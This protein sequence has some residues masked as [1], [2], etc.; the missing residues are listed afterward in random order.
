LNNPDK[1]NVL[2]IDGSA[3][4]FLHANKP[5]YED[6]IKEHV[7]RLLEMY[8]TDS[9][10][11]FLEKSKS[12]FRNCVASTHIYKG[13]REAN[14]DKTNDYLPYLSEVFDACYKVFNPIIYYGIEND[15]ALSLTAR[16]Y[17]DSDDYNPIIVGDDSD[18]LSIEGTHYRMRRNEEMSVSYPGTIMLVD[19][20][21]QKQLK[22]TGL[23]STYSKVLKGAA[24]EN[25]KGIPGYG[26]KKV[27]SLLKDINNEADMRKLCF[28]LFVKEFGYRH[29][30]HRLNEGFR[31]C[32]LLKYNKYFTLPPIQIFNKQT[33]ETM[34]KKWK[35]IT[36]P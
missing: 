24:K 3:F 23:Y 28:D 12:N 19:K 2:L 16:A 15:D 27:Y 22:A 17:N 7:G 21:K 8:D 29:G 35:S 36:K 11:F 4:V 26:D 13:H 30:V 20:S 9:Y 10:V 6:T 32:Y 33:N 34:I 31:L 5:N 25:Y 1:K 18:L 14:R